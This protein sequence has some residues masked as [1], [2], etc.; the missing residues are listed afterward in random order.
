MTQRVIGI[1][2]DPFCCDSVRLVTQFHI[3]VNFRYALNNGVP[4]E[5]VL[6]FTGIFILVED[7]L[8]LQVETRD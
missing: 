8:M 7:I 2:C 1:A 5:N 3:L 4:R 6:I